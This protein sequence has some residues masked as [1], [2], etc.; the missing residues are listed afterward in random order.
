MDKA[1]LIKTA[2]TA[3]VAVV[4]KEVVSWLVKSAKPTA[5]NVAKTTW[6]WTKAVWLWIRLH[7]KAIDFALDAGFLIWWVTFFLHSPADGQPVTAAAVRMQFLLAALIIGQVSNLKAA[8]KAWALEAWEK[9]AA[10]TAK[11]MADQPALD[12]L[13]RPDTSRNPQQPG[14]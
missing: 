12:G 14:G 6:S 9:R 5:A 4:A 10:A 3:V 2:V 8:F 13:S 7:W 1:E 11:R